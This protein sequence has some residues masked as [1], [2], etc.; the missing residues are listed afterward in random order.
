MIEEKQNFPNYGYLFMIDQTF[1]N[2]EAL[3]SW[4]H[5]IDE[6]IVAPRQI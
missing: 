1:D 3:M 6:I 5:N 2:I 4:V